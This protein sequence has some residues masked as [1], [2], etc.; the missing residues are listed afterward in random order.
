MVSAWSFQHSN[1][2]ERDL[3]RKF[4]APLFPFSQLGTFIW[5]RS[6]L[7]AFGRPSPSENC[8]FT[9]ELVKDERALPQEIKESPQMDSFAKI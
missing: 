5:P 1:Q 9:R 8:A 6:M 2:N 4:S 3:F 7:L